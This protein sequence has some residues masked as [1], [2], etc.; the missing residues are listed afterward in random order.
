MH[1]DCRPQ[2]FWY[3]IEEHLR[4]R[5]L[6]HFFLRKLIILPLV[7][8]GLMYLWPY[9]VTKVRTRNSWIIYCSNSVFIKITHL[10]KMLNISSWIIFEKSQRF[11]PIKNEWIFGAGMDGTQPKWLPRSL[12]KYGF[13]SI[14][15]RVQ[16]NI[17]LKVVYAIIKRKF[18]LFL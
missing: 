6:K 9:V 12:G 10:L 2:F 1:H 16:Y 14:N 5:S 11:I 18:L 8:I 13:C 7:S 3:I 15:Q 17:Y 4:E